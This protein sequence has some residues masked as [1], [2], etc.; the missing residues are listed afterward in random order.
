MTLTYVTTYG[1]RWYE[2]GCGK[3]RWKTLIISNDTIH[4]QV[5]K[6][7]KHDNVESISNLEVDDCLCAVH[8]VQWWVKLTPITY[9]W[10]QLRQ[11]THK[12][13][14]W[15]EW[16]LEIGIDD[17][18]LTRG[19][20]DKQGVKCENKL[21]ATKETRRDKVDTIEII[22]WRVEDVSWRSIQVIT[23]SESCY[24]TYQHFENDETTRPIVTIH[25]N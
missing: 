8:D 25:T 20:W 11:G 19:W 1:I 3:L 2:W 23:I 21:G 22:E 14:L 24:D 6:G 7:R 18:G 17:W 12:H 10:S 4:V 5:K 15:D 13:C 16:A 9:K